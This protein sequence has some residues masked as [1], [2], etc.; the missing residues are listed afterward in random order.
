MTRFAH[1]LPQLRD[2]QK[3]LIRYR[4]S[5]GVDLTATLYL[6][7][8]YARIVDQGVM[9]GDTHYIWTAGVGMLAITALQVACSIAAI[10]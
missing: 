9:T 8:L 2:V 7:F 4:R 3:E 5:D 6:P 10:Q 1:P